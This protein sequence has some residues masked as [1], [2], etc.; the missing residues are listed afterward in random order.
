M[1]P[2]SEEISLTGGN[3]GGEDSSDRELCEHGL[4]I[5]SLKEM[6]VVE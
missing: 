3:E 6:N 1:T 5:S 2:R 4:L